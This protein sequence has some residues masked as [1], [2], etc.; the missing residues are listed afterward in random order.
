MSFRQLIA[1]LVLVAVGAMAFSVVLAWGQGQAHQKAPDLPRL[2][3]RAV[4]STPIMFTCPEGPPDATLIVKKDANG[5]FWGKAVSDGT[6]YSTSGSPYFIVDVVIPAGFKM[7]HADYIK[8]YVAQSNS[9]DELKDKTICALASITWGVFKR[10]PKPETSSY[11]NPAVYRELK[12]G[13]WIMDADL[14]QF[15]DAGFRT[16][17]KVPTPETSVGQAVVYRVAVLPKLGNQVKQAYVAWTWSYG[18]NASY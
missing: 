12:H 8:L 5:H 10:T 4:P 1:H 3:R 13:V 7:D 17:F 14:G 15:C 2:S 6:A 18:P 9:N 11:T 16:T